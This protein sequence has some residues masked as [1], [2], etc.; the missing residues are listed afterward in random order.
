MIIIC[1][2]IQYDINE[3]FIYAHI[4]CLC[5]FLDDLTLMEVKLHPPQL[6]SVI[7]F[8]SHAE[9]MIMSVIQVTVFALSWLPCNYWDTGLSRLSKSTLLFVFYHSIRRVITP[10]EGYLR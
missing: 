7:C 8:Q 4:G 6:P 9:G 1:V 2:H 3:I 10:Y 5:L